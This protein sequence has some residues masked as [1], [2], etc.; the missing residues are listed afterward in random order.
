MNEMEMFD[1]R[2]INV[3]SN[4]IMAIPFIL[5]DVDDDFLYLSKNIRSNAMVDI[6]SI[7]QNR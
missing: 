1:N 3:Y 2:K 7:L 5:H 4:I 6:R